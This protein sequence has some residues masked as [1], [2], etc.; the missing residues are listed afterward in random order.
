M[1][2]RNYLQ[3]RRHSPNRETILSL[4]QA[5]VSSSGGQIFIR[6]KNE[7]VIRITVCICAPYNC[8]FQMEIKKDGDKPAIF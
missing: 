8:R 5:I 2:A 6:K 7:T 4:I 3:Y 1:T